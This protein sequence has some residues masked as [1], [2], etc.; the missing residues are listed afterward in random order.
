LHS[1]ISI[2]LPVRPGIALLVLASAFSQ[3]QNSQPAPA[4]ESADQ[5]L[6]RVTVNLVQVDAVVTDS[7]GN[8][9]TDLTANDFLL[10]Q[11]G[12]P[13]KITHFS[14]ISTAAATPAPIAPPR[15]T[16]VKGAPAPPPVKLRPDQ[17]RRTVAMVVDDLGLSFESMA[18]IRSALKKFVDQQMQP[19]DLVAIIRTGAG[20]GALQQFTSDKNQ[21]YAA[22]ERV[23]YNPLGRGGVGAFAPVGGE[24]G[25]GDG[26]NSFRDEYFTRGTI[27]A[28]NFVIAGLKEMPGRK[29]VVLLSD[30]IRLFNE[31]GLNDI[32]LESMR[33]LTDAANRASV[34]I[35]GIDA[36][37][38][39]TLSLTAEDNPKGRMA[40]TGP[41]LARIQQQRREE[42]FRSQDG[43]NYLAQETGG[44]FLHDTNDI[45]GGMRKVLDDQ[46]GY[47]LI[48]YTPDD[49]TFQQLKDKKRQYHKLS[50]KLK[51][52]GLS[53]RSRTGFFGIPD[54]NAKPVYKTR[55]E[56]LF[57][58]LGSPFGGGAV[59]LRLTALFANNPKEGSFVQSLLHIEGRDLTFIDEPDDWHKAVI[60]I[61]LV[62]FG[63]NGV[64]MD[65]SSKTY[66][67]RLHGAMY[68]NALEHGFVY[69]VN[70]PVKKPGAY[71][72]RTA[73]RDAATEKI[74]S[75][76]QF[77]EVPDLSK[78]HLTLSGLVVRASRP[79]TPAVPPSQQATPEQSKPEQAKPAPA[80]SEQA[81]KEE[82]EIESLGNPAVRIFRPGRR[83]DYALQ[84]LNSQED[85]ATK[86][87]Q[88]ETQLLLFHDGKQIY[89]GKPKPLDPQQSPDIKSVVTAG[90]LQLGSKME[91]GEYAM[92]IVVTDKLAKDKYRTV[93]QSIDFEVVK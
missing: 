2:G 76:S 75:A 59:H 8:Q 13:Q 88:L 21:L 62:T 18:Q 38:L 15:V 66:T 60:D 34:V 73:V 63:D 77:I 4:Q 45:A 80:L 28:L 53:I 5:P 56:Q 22:I 93:A 9:I 29:A 78:G 37:G 31:Q 33:Q 7:K 81:Q 43:L 79:A 30:S 3:T 68:R 51:E 89:A 58:A 57:A 55:E 46:K 70:H 6:L 48:G 16:P 91:P 74:G 82:T 64:E 27:G 32:I 12:K 24:A 90:Q 11:D 49:A 84:I 72:L 25:G 20:M 17:I 61:L 39:P 87:P 65:Q 52:P 54:R 83:L 35:Y 1:F 71:Q 14:Y 26:T 86:R 92:Q 10:L 44:L 41:G 50:V 23:K 36:R 47:Y 67:V 42:Y 69:S 40:L 85:S 19:G